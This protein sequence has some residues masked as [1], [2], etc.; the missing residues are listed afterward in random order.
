MRLKILHRT[1]YRYQPAVLT[2]QHQCHLNPPDDDW[3]R[4][5]DHQLELSP[6]P[7]HSLCVPDAF[8]NRRCF[9]ELHTAHDEFIAAASSLIETRLPSPLPDSPSWSIAAESLRYRAGA[10]ID[11]CVEFCFASPFVPLDARLADFA[12]SA[13]AADVPLLQAA[14]TLMR[15]IHRDMIYDGESTTIHTPVIEALQQRRGVCQDFAHLM[16]GCLRSLG[17]PARYVSGYLLT[18]PPVGKPRLIGAD[19]SHAWVQVASPATILDDEAPTA[20]R[21]FDFD[22]T[23][24]RSGAGTPGEDY[25]RLAVGRDFG[26]VS[27]LRGVIQGG[28]SHQ[29]DVE[30]TVA[31]EA[32][33]A[34]LKPAPSPVT[35]G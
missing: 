30:V 3:Q 6:E 12:R 15:T 2:A 34:Q 14:D 10:A 23:N 31:P 33:W 8:G 19:A 24:A 20:W 27:P 26:D 32:E 28:A 21:W 22:P 4:V 17:L 13:F 7:V 18:V 1:V 35:A 5:L 11:G 25:V 16:I 9:F 29:L